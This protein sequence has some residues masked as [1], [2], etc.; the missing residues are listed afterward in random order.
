MRGLHRLL[1]PAVLL[2]TLGCGQDAATSGG[3]GIAVSSLA[4]TWTLALG[5]SLP[6]ADSIADRD[7]TVGV[8]GSEDDVLPAGSLTFT[9]LWTSAGGMSGTVY[10]TIN[11][12]NRSVLLHLVRQ[13][14]LG[15]GMEIRGSLDDNLA[16][17]GR[18][19][20]PYAG[21]QPI[22]SSIACTFNVTGSRTSP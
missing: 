12:Q 22:L 10:G 15:Y 6:C 16:F 19:F 4:G 17:S 1:M 14:S 11:V 20:D 21:Y 8:S 5:D 7:F 3:G 9:D 13:D 2:A 18:A